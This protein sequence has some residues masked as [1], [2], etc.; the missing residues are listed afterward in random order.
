MVNAMDSRSSGPGSSPCWR[1]C[2]V[3][4]VKTLFVYS[5]SLHA[6][7]SVN[8]YRRTVRQTGQNFGVGWVGDNL[9]RG[10]IPYRNS[11][12]RKRFMLRKLG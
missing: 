3:F 10:S 5:A 2:A 8:K 11:N 4:F 1:Q 7:W 9:Q 12:V 6:A